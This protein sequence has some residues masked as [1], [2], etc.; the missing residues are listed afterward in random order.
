M[1]GT[2]IGRLHCRP[3]PPPELACQIIQCLVTHVLVIL[4]SNL[5]FSVGVGLTAK[6]T[7]GHGGHLK[8][9]KV[10]HA[11]D[12]P[13]ALL[14]GRRHHHIAQARPR[15]P[16]RSS[17]RGVAADSAPIPP[18]LRQRDLAHAVGHAGRIRVQPVPRGGLLPRPPLAG[19]APEHEGAGERRSVAPY[20]HAQPD[21]RVRGFSAQYAVLAPLADAGRR[22]GGRRGQ[23][24]GGGRGRR[25]RRHTV[26]AI[27]L[28]Y[29][30]DARAIFSL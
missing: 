29:P 10:E 30:N 18:S 11:T 17:C 5:L 28:R 19:L 15:H 23:R 3:K 9:R 2:I 4:F 1:I 12:A 13:G 25:R 8:H 6:L 21:Q 24:D 20:L 27:F 16:R 22:P 7:Y 14:D 26:V